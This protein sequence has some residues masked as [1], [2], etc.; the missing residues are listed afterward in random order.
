MESKDEQIK[1][2]CPAEKAAKQIVKAIR[3]YEYEPYIG[4]FF[5]E[6]RLA[7]FVNRVWPWLLIRLIPSK[8]VPK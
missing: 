4:N 2:G 7:L 5:G 3:K 8:G 1:G 6:E